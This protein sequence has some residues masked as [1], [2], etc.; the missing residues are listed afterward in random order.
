MDLGVT[1]SRRVISEQQ[2][3]KAKEWIKNNPD[4]VA[5]YHKKKTDERYALMVTAK[6]KPCMDCGGTF[7]PECMDFDHRNKEEKE[8]TIA[9]KR[10]YSKARILAEI[11]KCDVV[12]ANCHR[13]RSHGLRRKQVAPGNF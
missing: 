8:F 3:A 2:K 4:K 7:P 10:S 6:S 11:A 12:C 13:I 9:H 1:K 5:R